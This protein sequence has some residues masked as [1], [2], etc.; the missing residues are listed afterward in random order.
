MSSYNIRIEV[1]PLS[2][3]G[4]PGAEVSTCRSS[5]WLRVHEDDGTIT[6]WVKAR[7]GSYRELRNELRELIMTS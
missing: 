6:P 7:L 5:L 4:P 2:H 3:G 1:L